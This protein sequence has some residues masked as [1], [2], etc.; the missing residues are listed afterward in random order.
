MDWANE[1]Y[2]RLYTRDTASWLSWPWQSRALWPL[3]LRK[4]DRTGAIALG[5]TGRKGLAMLVG[6]PINVASKG[7]DGLIADGC[8]EAPE[9][10]LITPR[11]IEAQECSAPPA[12]RQRGSRERKRDNLRESL[13]R[14]SHA[15]TDGHAPSR[16]VTD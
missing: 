9:G 11:F 8:L 16:A 13:D 3:L 7:A 6:L 14:V 12:E 5:R 15:V 2:C 4:A 10:Y 1:R